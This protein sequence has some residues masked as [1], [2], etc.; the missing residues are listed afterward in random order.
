MLGEKVQ[1]LDDDVHD[2]EGLGLKNCGN[3]LTG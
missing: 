1:R 3:F 2:D